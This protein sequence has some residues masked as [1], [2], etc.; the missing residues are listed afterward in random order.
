MDE[1]VV[2]QI[3]F[4]ELSKIIR[5]E[6]SLKEKLNGLSDLLL[7][8]CH[9]AVKDTGIQFHTV[10]SIIAYTGHR[11][12]LPG[13]LLYNLHK[14][15]RQVSK[16]LLENTADP[17]QEKS[18]YL[19]GIK[20]GSD[21]VR[22]IYNASPTPD[23]LQSI[24]SDKVYLLQEDKVVQFK[25]YQRVLLLE[26]LADEDVLLAIDQSSPDRNIRIRYNIEGRNE[27]FNDTVA[28]LGKSFSFPIEVNLIDVEIDHHGVYLPKAIVLEPD[29]LIDITAV[30]GCFGDRQINYTSYLTKKYLPVYASKYLMLGHIANFFLDE[31]MA[32]DSLSFKQLIQQVFQLNP[33]AFSLFDDATAREIVQRAQK[34]YVSLRTVIREAF[35]KQG[36]QVNHCFLEPTFYSEQ[37]GLQGRLDVLH[38]HPENDEQ[39]S[40]IELKSGKPFRANAYGLS[41]DHYVQTLLY[42]L[43]IKSM[44][45]DR[46]RPTNFILYSVKDTDHLRFA[47]AVRSQQYEALAARNRLIAIDA[48]LSRVDEILS[49]PDRFLT[50]L[51][52]DL[53]KVRGF[54]KRDLESL[55]KS[56]EQLTTLEKKYFLSM[57]ALIAR[58][59]RLAKVGIEGQSRNRGQAALWLNTLEEKEEQF[60]VI[61]QVMLQ[62]SDTATRDPILKFKRTQQTNPLAN[63]RKGDLALVHPWTLG[64]RPLASQ[65]FKG[66]IIHLTQ[67]EVWVRLRAKQFNHSI[68]DQYRYWNIEHDSLDSSF[69]SLYRALFKFAN[70]AQSD[71][72]RFLTLQAP[73]HPDPVEWLDLPMLTPEQNVVMR[74]M[75]A[76]QD[77]FLLWG[78]PG[79]GKT[80]IMLK[81]LVQHLF[82]HSQEE[83]LV[84]AYTNRAVDEVCRALSCIEGLDF[85]RIGSRYSTHPDFANHLLSTKSQ[86]I[87][88]R[89]EL[90]ELLGSYRIIVGTLSS[91]M[92]K[93]ELFKLKDF[94]RVIVDEATQVLE[95]T[96]AGLIPNFRK[97]LMIGDH[98]QLP[99]VITQPSAKRLV[100][101]Q[102]LHAIGLTDLGNSYF[103]RVYKRCA[104][105][106]W[107]WAYDKLMQQGRMHR[108][109]MEFPS[110]C[111]YNGMLRTLPHTLE[112]GQQ[113][114]DALKLHGNGSQLLDLLSKRRMLF[115]PMVGEELLNSKTN[116][117]EAQFTAYLIQQF[118]LLYKI[119]ERHL[120]FSEMGII[121]PYK[122]QI[123]MIRRELTKVDIEVDG[124]SIDTVE[125]YQGGAR[126]IIIISLC[127]NSKDQLDYLSSHSADGIDR[128]LN[129]ALTR[130]REQLLVLG[131]PE[132]LASRPFYQSFIDS[133]RV[134]ISPQDV[135][136][137][138]DAIPGV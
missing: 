38:L 62:K 68:F 115:F 132:V 29:F 49:H 53:T 83:I 1:V 105:E 88:S 5:K 20:V 78:P 61:S 40:I 17:R 117:L 31:L 75:L 125:R 22:L 95:P 96:M 137:S 85:L 16:C 21:L 26:R 56:F 67:E 35:P 51:R 7:N 12:H 77:Y 99:A 36:I 54:A 84:A 102:G 123:A 50:L 64:S 129:V 122:A 55:L 4:K 69:L 3:F 2:G 13:R 91:V 18:L 92:G 134:D 34:H 89:K 47:P 90:R 79:T 76:A 39:A 130:A 32:D 93:T 15:R 100:A 127:A 87:T 27:I 131:N 119:N 37:Y 136:S 98:K 128:K 6:V 60:N 70:A 58:E 104:E 30:A 25:K 108:D 80:S 74:K 66:T 41:H 101:D 11:Y 73:A 52:E 114:N 33:L 81:H 124:L 109:I 107:D 59:H 14:F 45:G 94:D 28:L 118:K 113:Q 42:D 126:N 133:Y 24:P 46:L 57:T 111:F 110:K 82:R 23:I 138:L 43:L 8:I 97:V 9:H 71:R 65:L 63:F 135:L 48:R 44:S 106:G 86:S 103:E 72:Q 120:D 10:F 19:L 116:E 121:T 112:R